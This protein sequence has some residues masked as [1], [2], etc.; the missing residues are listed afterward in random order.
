[1]KPCLSLLLRRL[2][3][4]LTSN[5][6]FRILIY[7]WQIY[8]GPQ[9]NINQNALPVKGQLSRHYYPLY[10]DRRPGAV[11]R[12][13]S[14]PVP[15]RLS[16]LVCALVTKETLRSIYTYSV[17]HASAR[18]PSLLF[19]C[20]RYCTSRLLHSARHPHCA[21]SGSLILI[22]WHYRF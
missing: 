9:M 11:W 15:N 13:R 20:V 17:K 16:S 8:F 12:F 10:D 22:L 5:E 18:F 1:M 7:E 19:Q 6:R 21:R 4:H 3:S 14:V 2:F